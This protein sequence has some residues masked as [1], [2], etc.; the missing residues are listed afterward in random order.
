MITSLDELANFAY[1]ND[2]PIIS[3]SV[4]GVVSNILDCTMPNNILEIGLCIGYSSSLMASKGYVL[5]V[6]SIER[7]EKFI[8]VAKKNIEDLGLTKKI[9]IIY[10]DASY[11]LPN[12]CAEK[13]KYDMIFLDAAKGQYIKFLPFILELLSEGG[14][15]IS[16]NISQ[17]GLLET[18]YE[19]IPKRQ[20]TIYKNMN[21][22]IDEIKSNKRL[23][24]TVVE[25]GD[26]VSVSVLLK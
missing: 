5:K 14:I 3:K 19:E 15:L 13:N 16:D 21:L 10:G 23:H 9:D 25:I 26:G 8:K 2:F 4:A 7:A 24:S 17:K 1:N 20:R 12:L 22:F 6:T 18:P 11:V